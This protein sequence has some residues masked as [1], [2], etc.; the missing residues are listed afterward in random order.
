MDEEPDKK[1]IESETC[2]RGRKVSHTAHTQLLP[3]AMTMKAE[4][5][6][7]EEANDREDHIDDGQGYGGWNA[8]KMGQ[9]PIA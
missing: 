4:A 9:K 7:D 1:L 6:V 3:V 5:G 2:E 8:A